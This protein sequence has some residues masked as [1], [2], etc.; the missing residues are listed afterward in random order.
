MKFKIKQKMMLEHLNYAIKGISNKNLIPIL[1]CFK[2]ELTEERL[3]ILS[4]DN[5][6]AIKT[7]IENKD[8]IDVEELGEIV[9]AGRFLFDIVRK[10]DNDVINF[11]EIIDNQLLI[12]TSNSSFKLN[13][14]NVNEFPDID[15]EFSSQ[16]ILIDNKVF[17]NAIILDDG[18]DLEI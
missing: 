2:M 4:T 12:T 3:F 15:L 18:E 16:P 14:N 9:I 5:E 10:L 11:E 17:K 8:L 7:F 6:I 13:C 1:N